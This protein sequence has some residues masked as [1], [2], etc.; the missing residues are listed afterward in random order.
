VLFV[1]IILAKRCATEGQG[2]GQCE[3]GCC[4]LVL[5]HG[6]FLHLFEFCFAVDQICFCFFCLPAFVWPSHFIAL[7]QDAS[8]A[9]KSER[10]EKKDKEEEAE[11]A[12]PADAAGTRVILCASALARDAQQVAVLGPLPAPLVDNL[13][14]FTNANDAPVVFVQSLLP[15]PSVGRRA[16]GVMYAN[17]G[18]LDSILSWADVGS[19]TFVLYGR[20][21]D[22]LQVCSAILLCMWVICIKSSYS[23]ERRIPFAAAKAQV[24]GHRHSCR[25]GECS[26]LGRV[27]EGAA[28]SS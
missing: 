25:V 2:R 15:R 24:Q 9:E 6:L 10:D 17:P 20:G 23:D 8:S 22:L 21:V 18:W 28:G 4:L 5:L 16:A 26:G 3:F 7:E 27:R 11:E 19:S 14:S 1:K 13:S 12:V